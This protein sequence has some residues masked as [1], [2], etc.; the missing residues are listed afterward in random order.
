MRAAWD[1][2][3]PVKIK[4]LEDNLFI[5]QFD[6]LGDWEKVAQGGPWHFKGNPVI[7]A[8]YDGFTKPS[9]IELLKFEIWAHII[10]LP[11]AYHGKVKALAS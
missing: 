3:M 10:D 2:A 6:C 5:M 9:T 8:P 11:P 7:I 4:S 1:L